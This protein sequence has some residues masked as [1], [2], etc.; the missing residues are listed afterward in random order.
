MDARL[1]VALGVAGR[2]REL[3]GRVVDRAARG[4]VRVQRLE[5]RALS[6]SVEREG[7]AREETHVDERVPV[8]RARA[9]DEDT[10][11]ARAA[12]MKRGQCRPEDRIE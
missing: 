4:D 7:S 12:P 5:R 2:E 11:Q 1:L 10:V 3:D 6:V 9:G 8:G